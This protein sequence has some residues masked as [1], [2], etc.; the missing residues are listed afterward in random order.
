MF[1]F[2]KIDNLKLF[3]SWNFWIEKESLRVKRDWKI[4]FNDHP[5]VFWNKLENNFI[6]V[7]FF[8]SQIELITSINNSI[9]WV[10]N[11]IKTLHDI[12][13]YKLNNIWEYLWNNSSYPHLDIR[14]IPLAKFD[15][16]KKWKVQTKYRKYL[17][18]KYW[19]EKM[20]LSWIHFNF[21]FSD[22]LLKKLFSITNENDYL[23]F[24]N[25]VYINSVKIISKYKWL[26]IYLFWTDSVLNNNLYGNNFSKTL[27]WKS[28]RN[29]KFWYKNL[30]T[31]DIS[32]DSLEKYLNSIEKLINDKKITHIRESYESV[33]IK[34]KNNKL[35]YFWLNNWIEYIEIRLLDIDPFRKI[36]LNKDSLYFIHI[37]LINSLFEKGENLFNEYK[38][39][40][41]FVSEYW[42]LDTF[43]IYDKSNM[44]DVKVVS[45][46]I[47]NNLL[48]LLKKLWKTEKNIYYKILNKQLD[49]IKWKKIHLS[50]KIKKCILKKW[51]NKF[52]LEKLHKNTELS[53]KRI[54][55][56]QKNKIEYEKLLKKF[57]IKKL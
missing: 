48:R 33:R 21:S 47:I 44:T 22:N 19:T 17:L 9:N 2:E 5:S 24:K 54:L 15:N 56:L 45:V 6:T 31:L 40:E 14:N 49:K 46:N 29:S 1:D 43:S 8:E 12:V 7:D 11:E 13:S 53:N 38:K 23:N 27:N 41:E 35:E 34:W 36:W 4:S 39:N 42:C 32:Y 10:Y 20:L 50:R 51:Y 3:F 25:N 30:E 26:I 18:D 16:N 28:F 37:L 52:Y 57:G 55:E